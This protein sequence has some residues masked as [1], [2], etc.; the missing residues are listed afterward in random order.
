MGIVKKFDNFID[1][2]STSVL[3]VAVMTMLVL[4]V[5]N[6]V[7]RWFNAHVM[8]IEPLVRYLVMMSAF[9]G[10]VIATG[11]KSHIGIDI[12]AKY[13]ENQNL[14]QAHRITRRVID[15]V[16]L[17]VLVYLVKGCLGFVESEAEYGRVVFLGIHA[18]Y[19][20]MILPIG[21][22]LMGI[23]FLLSLILSFGK[24]SNDGEEQ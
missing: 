18:K 19:L 8:W 20:A 13:F 23:R 9:L 17:V 4:S 16:C 21:F 15:V 5:L 7:L 14:H 11:K 1:K 22:S 6:I 3:V 12:V 10:G 2:L 24:L